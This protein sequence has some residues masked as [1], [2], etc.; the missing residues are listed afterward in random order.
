M[1]SERTIEA[2]RSRDIFQDLAE[3]FSLGMTRLISELSFEFSQGRHSSLESYIFVHDI[4]ISADPR[5][6]TIKNE[7][8]NLYE[9]R[10]FES[11]RK[12]VQSWVNDSLEPFSEKAIENEDHERWIEICEQ[13]IEKAAVLEQLSEVNESIAEYAEILGTGILAMRLMPSIATVQLNLPKAPR[14]DRHQGRMLVQ[15][16]DRLL[17][18]LPRNTFS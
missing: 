12:D 13:A 5:W 8:Q 14:F 2:Y 16:T 18:R 11:R 9:L 17:T 7:E 6:E 15:F 1:V 3:E 10:S 4:G